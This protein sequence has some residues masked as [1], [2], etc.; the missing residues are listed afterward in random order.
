MSILSEI[1]GSLQRGEDDEVAR[2]VRQAL[3]D[4]HDAGTV[5]HEGLIAGMDVVGDQFREREIFLPDVLLAARAMYA[6]LALLK[7][8]LARDGVPTSGTVVIGSVKGDLH[9]IGKNL[10]AIMLAGAGFEVVDLGNDVPPERFVDAACERGA[11]VIGLSALLTTTMP[12]MKD[13]VEL[14]RARG[15][16]GRIKVIVGG[17]PVSEAWAR[18]IGA[19]AYG[20]DAASAVERVRALARRA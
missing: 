12:V 9:D 20:Y 13:V 5:L 4:G 2:L 8:L 6:G 18:Q 17:A 15:L 14:V 1:A 7:P 11:S 19:D 16:S 10:V 3:D